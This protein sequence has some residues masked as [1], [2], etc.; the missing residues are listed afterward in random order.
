MLAVIAAAALSFYAYSDLQQRQTRLATMQ[1]DLEANKGHLATATA[2]VTNVSFAQAWHGGDPRYLTVL[3]DLTNAMPEDGQ[4]YAT[5]ITV[6]EAPH[7]KSTGSGSPAANAAKQ[8]EARNLLNQLFGKT[9]DQQHVQILLDR[10]KRVPNFTDVKLG[11]TQDLGKSHE[12][13]FSIT[14]TYVPPP[15]SQ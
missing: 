7:P 13:S 3:R 10:M 1:N 12:V 6:H 9:S 8:A 2:F 5:S 4:T 14:F 11:G 15:K